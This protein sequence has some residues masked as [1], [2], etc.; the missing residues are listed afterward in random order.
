MRPLTKAVLAFVTAATAAMASA[1]GDREVASAGPIAATY[2]SVEGVVRSIVVDDEVAGT[3]HSYRVLSTPEG[4]DNLLRG[5]IGDTLVAGSHYVVHGTSNGKYLQAQSA[6]LMPSARVGAAPLSFAIDGILRLGHIDYQNGHPSEYFFAVFSADGHHKHLRGAELLDELKN[7]MDVSTS[8]TIAADGT[9][10]VEHIVVHQHPSAAKAAPITGKSLTTRTDTVFVVPVKFPT[11]TAAPFTYPAEA[12]TTASLNTAVFGTSPTKSVAEYYKDVSFGQQ[13]LTGVTASDKGTPAHWLAA[14]QHPPE[15][16]GGNATCDTDFIQTQGAAAAEAKGYTA[17]NLTPGFSSPG[18]T[19]P[20]N[21][22]VFVFTTAGFNCGWSGLAYIGYG[23]AFINQSSQLLVIGHELGHTFGLYH[24]GSLDCGNNPI[25][26]TCSVSEYGDPFDVMGN[27]NAMHFSAFQKQNLEW[28]TNASVVTHA[29]GTATYTLSPIESGGGSQYAIRIPAGPNRT[30]FVEYRQPLGFDSAIPTANAD[31]AQVRVVRPLEILC[32]TCDSG[33]NDTELLDMSTTT[34]TF[35]D[36]VLTT[37]TRF[38]DAYYGVIVDVLSR[39]ATA[40]DVKVTSLG[41]TPNPDFDASGTTDLLWNN[42]SSGQTSMSLMNGLTASSTTALLADTSKSVTHTGDLDGDGKTDLIWRTTSGTT[43][44]WL[45]N[46]ATMTASKDLLSDPNWSVQFVADFDGDGKQDIVWRNSVTGM[47]TIWLMDGLTMKSYAVI[48]TDPQW[49]ITHV[50]DFNGD[51]KADLVWY[52]A[53]TGM[54]SIWLMNGLSVLST[55][56]VQISP[57]GWRVT[58]VGDFDGDGKSD[59]VWSNPSTGATS[60]WLMN[61]TG[62]SSYALVPASAG[63]QVTQVGDFDGDGKDDLVW[64]NDATGATSI[65]LMNGTS[66]KASATELV[67][68]NW[69]VTQV[70]D[71]D[72]DGKSDLVWRN[73]ST[74]ATS[75]WL[76]NGTAMRTYA[77]ISTVP[78]MAVVPAQPQ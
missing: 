40:L 63:Y 21:H 58:Q 50:G 73:A 31:G 8:G 28:I 68:P 9:F 54:T 5:E 62:Y 25:G 77:V 32:S 51:G 76:M 44:A 49:Q 6:D 65:W 45:M 69:S 7:G 37:G 29:G 35:N 33:N 16:S 67:D 14:T 75:L 34:S 17:A 27:I 11:N 30:Y 57:N 48:Y 12:F 19:A 60:I 64:R 47:T 3:T 26:G 78:A 52:N 70:V 1:H 10:V 15:D 56:V 59:L 71:T 61:G 4:L 74:G 39:T 24:A 23:L 20:V 38:V 66:I 46:G 42:S 18:S 13:L 43:S 22:V 55:R 2:A 72:G 36:A 41:K 53:T